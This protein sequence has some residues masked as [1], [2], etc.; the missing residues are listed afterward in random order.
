MQNF[1]AVD[2]HH[3]SQ[4]NMATDMT[5]ISLLCTRLQQT[6]V[7]VSVNNWKNITCTFE[8]CTYKIKLLTKIITINVK[9]NTV[10]PLK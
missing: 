1:K 9:L 7:G 6:H 4:Q 8:S 10:A 3:L 5:L 2:L